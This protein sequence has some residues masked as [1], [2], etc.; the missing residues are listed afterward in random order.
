MGDATLYVVLPTH[1]QDAG[2][3]L[4]S[5]GLFLGANR[6]IRLLLNGPAG[7]AYDRWPRRGLFIASLLI[8]ACSTALYAATRGFWPLL[9]ARLLWG[10]AWSG[11]WV[12]GSAIILDITTDQNRGRW[13]GL[14]Q[15]WFFFGA[16]LG[17]LGGGWP[18]TC[19]ATG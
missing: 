2:V 18:R 16:A 5:V 6:A 15:T 4:G 1:T 17:S 8:G 10:V 9:L 12:G 14:Y 11:I 3:A 13:T 19:L 7:L